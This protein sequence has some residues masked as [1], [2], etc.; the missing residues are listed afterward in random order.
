MSTADKIKRYKSLRS[1]DITRVNELLVI[2]NQALYNDKLHSEFNQRFKQIESIYASFDKYQSSIVNSIVSS[3]LP[4]ENL[5]VEDKVRTDFETIYFQTKA[6]YENIFENKNIKP[7]LD[8]TLSGLT[9]S[10][11]KLP[12]IKITKFTGDIK[13]FSSFIDIYNALVHNNIE[14]SNIEKFTHLHSYLE[15]PPKALI[16]CTPMT[17]NNYLVAY[18]ALVDRYLNPRL[19]ATAYW[20]EIENSPRLTSENPQLLRKLLDIFSENIAALKNMNYPTEHWDFILVNKLLKR[21]DPETISRFEIAHGSNDFPT[22]KELTEFLSKQCIAYDTIAF[23][24]PLLRYKPQQKT[25]QQD[26]RGQGSGKRGLSLFTQTTPGRLCALCS[27]EHPI[28]CCSI[29]TNKSPQERLNLV[30]QNNWCGNCIS[31]THPTRNCKSP[32]VCKICKYRHHS[33]LHLNNKPNQNIYN[34][35]PKT[36]FRTVQNSQSGV[37]LPDQTSTTIPKNPQNTDLIGPELS[38]S[39]SQALAT[40]YTPNTGT[41]SLNTDVKNTN[42]LLSTIQLDILD[43][44]GNYQKV[45]AL[46]DSAS[47]TNFI[48]KK[49]VQRLGLP[50]NNYSISIFGLNNMSTKATQ[51]AVSCQIRP[52]NAPH[53]IYNF[54]AAVLDQLCSALPS[55][56]ISQTSWPHTA[57]LKLADDE[58]YKPANIDLLLG[59]DVFPHVLMEGVVHG[60]KDEPTAIHTVFGWVLMGTVKSEA[61]K[62]S[63]SFFTS[64]EANILNQTIKQFWEIEE[65]PP[66]NFISPE[67]KDCENIFNKTHYRESSGRYVVSLPFRDNEPSFE[68][69]RAVAEKRFYSLEK[70][71]N[72]NEELKQM[73]FDFIRDYIDTGHMTLI[74]NPIYNNFSYY[75]PHHCVLKPESTT[76][77]LR[78]V[79]DGSAKAAN[80]LSLN[81]TLL[82]GPKLQ[83]DIF[84][85]ILNFRLHNIVFIA[86]IRQM[87]RQILV[88]EQHRRYQK[89]LWRF[90]EEEMLQEYVLNTVTYGV[91]CAPYLAIRT[92][93]QLAIDERTNFPLA[94]KTLLSDI[95]MDDLVSGADSVANARKIQKQL[96]DLL[97][98]GGFELRKWASN[99]LEL[100]SYLPET[101]LY[102]QNVSFDLDENNIIKILGLKWNPST[103]MFSYTVNPLNRTCSKRNMLSELARIYDPA[104][105]LSPLTFSCKILIQQLFILGLEW[106]DI[107]PQNICSR[108]ETYKHE[109]TQVSEITIP[110]LIPNNKNYN[111]ELHGFS[112]A[113]E[114]GYCAVVYIRA[115]NNF[116]ISTFLVCAKSKI[117]PLKTISIP[118]MELCGAHLLSKLMTFI[119]NAYLALKFL[120]LYAWTDSSVVLSWIRSSP[121]KWKT[122]VSNRVAQIQDKISPD[123]WHYV[124]TADNP[125]DCGSRGLSPSELRNHLGWWVG[126]SWLSRPHNEWPSGTP[127][128][129]SEDR[130]E[131]KRSCFF[132]LVSLDFL[133]TLLNKF[134]SLS[135]IIRITAYMLRFINNLSPN[136]NKESNKILSAFELHNALLLIIKFTQNKYFSEDLISI[137]NKKLPSKYLRKLNP[138][139]DDKNVLR[140]G[141]RL[142]R[143]NLHYDQ[144][145]PIL[146]PRS[147]RL[148]DLLIEEKHREFLHPGAQ[149]LQFLIF[150]NFWILSAR[151]AIRKIIS[152]CVK[153]WKLNPRPCQP[154]MGN[155]P[156]SRISEA[157]AFSTSGVDLCGPLLITLGKTRGAKTFKAWIC[158]FVC[159]ATK[160]MHIELLS[161]L[162]SEC[163]LA[164]LRRFIARRGRCSKLVSDCGT[165]FVGANKYLQDIFHIASETEKINWDFNPPASP[166]FGGL[167]EAGVKSVKTH[168]YRVIGSQVL[169]YEELYTVLVQIE[170]VLNSRPLCPLSSDPNDLTVLTPGHFLTQEPLSALPDPNLGEIKLNR[171]SR[172]QLLQRLHSDFWSRWHIEYLHTLNQRAKW[173]HL[174]SPVPLDTLVLIKNENAPPLSWQMARIVEFHKGTDGIARVAT[175]RTRQGLLKRPL[176]KL[177]PLPNCDN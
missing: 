142:Q 71:L 8:Q 21:L 72:K 98:K 167:F 56:Q 133:E 15:G 66:L 70:R 141:G 131:E 105:Y 75:F 69:S 49:C 44:R 121:H 148:T 4:T 50:I 33:L 52:I 176:V 173:N 89:I 93:N 132:S 30:K 158:I 92:L 119:L 118:R 32:S 76:T 48:S 45:R 38:A 108:W 90:S 47:Q 101:A 22:Y 107:P 95:Y 122:F 6:I 170:A 103:D 11:V 147:S 143:S 163:F 164:G 94:S 156:I 9:T 13:L 115:S 138:F 74:K 144:K 127:T 26:N 116:D 36:N 159:F 17:G 65:I 109:L 88:T 139:F 1:I 177:C 3:D 111:Y 124:H 41:I 58:F 162:T 61:N 63:H 54:E 140:V 77:K 125:A 91:A 146:L 165:N 84:T 145:F 40:F 24:S 154:P 102:N 81:D 172:W 79:F 114:R 97:E 117:A 39:T 136:S 73:Y 126:P 104:G 96:I 160:A 169:T 59:S 87:Y 155:L 19:A 83:K 135:K 27:Q 62:I 151:R 106:D 53:P 80:G 168:L 157:K 2:A 153:C 82:I 5:E 57:N 35:G 128:E 12:D 175:V 25:F 31:T 68:G 174:D 137:K 29:F 150:Q 55:N 28:Y 134:S 14:L 20:N 34:Y 161:E 18:N 16:Q 99:S 113:S 100:L 166:H 67:E 43:S 85:I 149:T 120:R 37:Q 123:C 64:I 86:D 51:G 112:D 42:V 46:L 129:T 7:A 10:R 152:K 23:S 110:R 60:N 130:S 171:L 78:V